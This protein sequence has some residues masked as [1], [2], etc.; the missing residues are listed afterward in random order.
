MT[1]LLD[2]ALEY[3]AKGWPVLPL[4]NPDNGA[5][6]C[7]RSDCDSP[8]KHPRVEH[9]LKEATTNA[10]T[11]RTWWRRWPAANIGLR[12]GT[13]ADVLDLDSA[14]VVEAFRSR[15]KESALDPLSLPRVGTGKG[16]HVYFA[17]T[18][19]G[20]RTGVVPGVDWR[21]RDGYVLAPP[22]RHISGTEYAWRHPLNGT[23]PTAPAWLVE[24]VV[25]RPRPGPAAG[26][27][28]STSPYAQ[29][30]LEAEVTS[31]VQ[32]A[33]GTRNDC[34]NRAAFNLYQ[35]VAGGE[36]GDAEVSSALERP[37]VA[38]GLSA[39]EAERTIASGRQAGLQEPRTPPHVASI[40]AAAPTASKESDRAPEVP[41]QTAAEVA[42]GT[43][44]EVD[45]LWR[46]YLAAE[47]VVELDGK[48]KSG[49]TTF[50]ALLIAALLDG[51]PFLGRPTARTAVVYLTE[52]GNRTFRSLLVRAGLT[53][54]ADLHILSKR[55]VPG[56]DWDHLVAVA[57]AKLVETGARVLYVDTLGKLAGFKDDEENSAGKAATAMNPLQALASELKIVV[58]CNR[59]DRKSGGE[60]GES[61]RGSSAI[62]GDVDVILQISRVGGQGRE[63]RRS[64]RA[65]GR[66]DETPAELTIELT[67]D[68]YQEVSGT[69]ARDL[70]ASAVLAVL[71]E[72]EEDAVALVDLLDDLKEAGHN[73][74][75][76][77]AGADLLV[78]DGRAQKG[79]Q[80][81]PKG[82]LRNVY[83]QGSSNRGDVP[84]D[85]PFLISTT[86]RSSNE[87]DGPSTRSSNAAPHKGQLDAWMDHPVDAASLDVPMGL[88]DGWL[89]QED[90]RRRET[91]AAARAQREER[92][93]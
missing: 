6:S 69:E 49:K 2:A 87:Q 46:D 32:A 66:F 65:V 72:L 73:R 38:A 75:N 71:P 86:A 23:P 81:G 20:N 16:T 12:T 31:V 92:S 15:F 88:P 22:S 62:G 91:S 39:A 28:A 4:H 50:N 60:V 47:T 53:A 29:R 78:A 85:D 8:A 21:G 33:E 90:R 54:R 35:L 58:I 14:D 10:D 13:V 59:H 42:A 84:L 57:R 48:L 70:A 36:L 55:R 68:G 74:S 64:L 93:R 44:A 1:A 18:G 7:G 26:V 63:K 83:W 24:L 41:W 45:W 27:A 9:G 61:A 40:T 67:D 76:V 77:Y 89:E 25:E 17:P 82:H 79:R 34:L 5:C 30:A 11:L 37:A 52:E 80:K 3:A 56:L 19:A 51:S 43:P